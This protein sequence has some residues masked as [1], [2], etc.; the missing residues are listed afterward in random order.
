MMFIDDLP[1]F[2]LPQQLLYFR[3]PQRWH[4]AATWHALKV[5]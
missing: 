2:Q 3:A 5:S 1:S 4:A